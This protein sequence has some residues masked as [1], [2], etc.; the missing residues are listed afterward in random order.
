MTDLRKLLAKNIKKFRKIIGFSQENL[1]EL[2]KTSTTHIG[3]I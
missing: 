2:A 3:M 1:A